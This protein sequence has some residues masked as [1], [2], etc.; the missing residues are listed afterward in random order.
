MPEPDPEAALQSVAFYESVAGHDDVA[1]LDD[2]K[3]PCMVYHDVDDVIEMAGM[4]HDLSGRTRA[5]EDELEEKGWDVVWIE[6]GMAHYA[7]MNAQMCLGAFAPFLD[8]V[9]L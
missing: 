7:M 2:I 3:C 9:L 6:S 8:K 5:V 4:K 1:A